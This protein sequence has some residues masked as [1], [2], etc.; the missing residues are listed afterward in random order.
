MFLMPYCKLKVIFKSIGIE[1]TKNSIIWL[2]TELIVS[3]YI[4]Y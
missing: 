1:Q 4:G 3:I 2:S